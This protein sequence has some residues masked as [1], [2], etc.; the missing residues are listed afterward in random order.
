CAL[1]VAGPAR[2]ADPEPI[3]TVDEH[4]VH[5]LVGKAAGT[6]DQLGHTLFVVPVRYTLAGCD[7]GGAGLAE[8]DTVDAIVGQAVV[9][10]DGGRR[11]EVAAPVAARD[12]LH[13]L[14]STKPQ[15][16]PLVLVDG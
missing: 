13:A 9:A 16:P 15:P 7:P 10:A 11:I 2:G 5:L 6:I 3:T 14:A 4:R 1:A 8:G 12:D